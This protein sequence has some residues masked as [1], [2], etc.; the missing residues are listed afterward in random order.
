MPRIA[1][2]NNLREFFMDSV[3][4]AMGR[5]QLDADE[6]TAFYV[7]NLLTLFARSEALFD[8]TD[9]GPQLTPV[10]KVLAAAVEAEHT[11]QR[12]FALQRVGDV[13]LFIAGFLGEGLAAKLVGVDY[14]VSMGGTAYQTLASNLRGSVRGQAVG[15]VFSELAEKFQDFVDVLADVRE[16][17][18]A[19]E[20][21]ILRL[22]DTWQKTGSERAA[23]LLRGLG[24]EPTPLEPQKAH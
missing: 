1:K 5:Q 15:G 17:A 19:T 14:Y 10:A 13:S 22:Y 8:D 2:I 24:I 16:G 11:Q 12:N 3:T 21:D 9:D 7:V 6:H 23:R 4:D 20:A 18:E